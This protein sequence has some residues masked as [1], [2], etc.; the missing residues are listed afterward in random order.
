M[1]RFDAATTRGGVAL[2]TQAMRAVKHLCCEKPVAPD[3][4]SAP[5]LV[6]LA[7]KCTKYGV[8]QLL[9]WF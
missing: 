9:G 8:V 6:E 7:A 3:L 2:L 1:C 5:E 4:A